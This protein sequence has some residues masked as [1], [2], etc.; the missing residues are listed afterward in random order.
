MYGKSIVQ[1]NYTYLLV[2]LS[3]KISLIFLE[4]EFHSKRISESPCEIYFLLLVSGKVFEK[5]RPEGPISTQPRAT[6]WVYGCL[7][8]RPEGAKALQFKLL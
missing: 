2:L 5:L 4:H 1:K 8:L 6:P 7:G 3:S